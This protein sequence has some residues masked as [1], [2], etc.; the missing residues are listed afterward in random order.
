MG[1]IFDEYLER[2]L[3]KEEIKEELK[4]G[5]IAIPTSS[6]DETNETNWTS[7]KVLALL[8]NPVYAGIG[9]FPQIVDD[10]LWIKGICLQIDNLGSELVMRVLLDSLRQAFEPYK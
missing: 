2:I 1:N 5:P 7:A 9:P 10:E 6:S 4:K 8:A 3:E